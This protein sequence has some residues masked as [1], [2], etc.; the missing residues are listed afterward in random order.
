VELKLTDGGE[1]R[2][3]DGLQLEKRRVRV[4]RR[5]Q[6]IDFMNRVI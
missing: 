4:V 3:T 2:S 6:A 1:L 5:A